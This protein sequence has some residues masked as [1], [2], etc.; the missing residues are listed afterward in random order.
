MWLMT[1]GAKSRKS[2]ARALFLVFGEKVLVDTP[3]CNRH[4]LHR[5][6]NHGYESYFSCGFNVQ[7]CP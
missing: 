5:Y 2:L 4:P 1:D 6:A 3:Y 7:R